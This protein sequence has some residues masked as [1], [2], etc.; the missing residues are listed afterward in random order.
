MNYLWCG[1]GGDKTFPANYANEGLCKWWIM[2]MRLGA[3]LVNLITLPMASDRETEEDAEAHYANEL[4]F[5]YANQREGSRDDTTPQCV[6]KKR[7]PGVGNDV[8]TWFM[9]M[10]RGSVANMQKRSRGATRGAGDCNMQMIRMSCSS[11][12]Y[13]F[14][15]RSKSMPLTLISLKKS[16][17]NRRDVDAVIKWVEKV[18]DGRL[19]ECTRVSAHLHMG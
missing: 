17:N 13:G 15:R 18:V 8:T 14:Q 9:Q 16:G 7:R 12:A 11:F 1:G 19:L 3:T 6:K 2:Q 5:D 4:L 10:S